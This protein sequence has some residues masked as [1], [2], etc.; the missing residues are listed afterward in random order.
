[1]QSFTRGATR[2]RWASRIIHR[3]DGSRVALLAMRLGGAL[4]L[5]LGSAPHALLAFE[6][7]PAWLDYI[8][9]ADL[10]EPT[11]AS[12]HGPDALLAELRSTRERGY[13][14][15]DQDVTP[16]VAS[17]GAPIYDYSGRARAWISVGGLRESV[18]GD[19]SDTAERVV[20]AARDISRA[21]GYR[22]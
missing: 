1:M 8:E 12:P 14:V 22:N 5:H 15:S 13:S 16:G 21:L 11:T 17:L 18:L 2:A 7:E 9:Q 4:P 6:P 10:T 19:G 20:A 3:I